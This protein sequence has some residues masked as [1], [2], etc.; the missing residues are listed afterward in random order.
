MVTPAGKSLGA[1]SGRPGAGG[2]EKISRRAGERY[3]VKVWY[4]EPNNRM[5][6]ESY[7]GED[8]VVSAGGYDYTVIPRID[9]LFCD[10]WG[11]PGRLVYNPLPEME[12]WE[13]GGTIDLD[14]KEANVWQRQ[15]K[16]G[17]KVSQHTFYATPDGVPLRLHTIGVNIM[18]GSHFDEYLYTFKSF[19]T[20]F[21]DSPDAAAL[22][23]VPTV[24]EEE[25]EELRRK[26][27]EAGSEAAVAGAAAGIDAN[28]GATMVGKEEQE[29]QQPKGLGEE[30]E[31][32]GTTVPEDAPCWAQRQR[33]ELG[34][35]RQHP[36]AWQVHSALPNA[37]SL[38]HAMSYNL[39]SRAHGRVHQ[40]AHD[41]DK[42]LDR[43]VAVAAKVQA[44][45]TRPDASYKLK[46]N[47]W[48]DWHP[49]EWRSAMLPNLRLKPQ[50]QQRPDGTDVLISEM[51]GAPYR[52]KSTFRGT[53]G[54]SRA[55]LPPSVDWRGTGADPGVK[56]Q[57]MCGSCYTFAATGTM[58][59]TWFVATGQ[60]RSFSEQQIIDCAWDYGPN[61]CFGGYYQP[62]LNYVAE[63][64]GMALEQDYTYRGEPGYCRA[65]NHTR[66]GLFSG[67]MNVE[68]RNEL[69]LMEA[70]AKYGPIAVSVNADP[71]AFSFYSEGVFDEP[72]CTTRMRDLD[73]TVTLFGYGS[74]DGKDY[75]LVR[76][77][78][79]H[80]WG[81][82]GYIKIVRG[83]HDCG[84]ATDPAVALV[85]D[86]HVRPEA[87]AA[88]QREAARWD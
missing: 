2:G 88:A 82:D 74:Q 41:Y 79:S 20:G 66:V 32:Q 80:F 87:Q 1:V 78:W 4:D 57:G 37:W 7:D 36:F 75:W 40:H 3:T 34:G 85:V 60:R 56:D 12:F 24:C 6:V 22:F 39:W 13:F 38:D 26:H 33:Q 62:V 50:V 59:G 30:G 81:D 42:R 64:G 15:N 25:I 70:V 55:D 21:P 44:H 18:S 9:K 65:S 72:A 54:L 68:S 27:A 71:E 16:A 83:K 86:R 8:V 47:Q 23:A 77:S 69:A 35:R 31:E 63:Q 52:P 49:E 14:G 58:D 5:R 45:N 43:F 76:N 61:G 67:Y 73:H 84:I 28:A 51:P 11:G 53:P 48:A 19:T 10:V 29:Q 17:N 46:L